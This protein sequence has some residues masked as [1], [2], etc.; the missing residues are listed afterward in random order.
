MPVAPGAEDDEDAPD[1]PWLDCRDAALDSA[2][3]DCPELPEPDEPGVPEEELADWPEDGEEP[4]VP[5]WPEVDDEVE[6]L[7]VEDCDPAGAA[8]LDPAE[9]D[10]E[11]LSG[12]PEL[13]DPDAPPDACPAW[14][15]GW[16]EP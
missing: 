6:P 16:E 15:G 7:E 1:D 10:P 4:G 8:P 13:E 9:P 3:R 2:E 11:A 14:P 12:V 5:P